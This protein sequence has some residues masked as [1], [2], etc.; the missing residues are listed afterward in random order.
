MQGSPTFSLSCPSPRASSTESHLRPPRVRGKA[1]AP[2]SL[3]FSWDLGESQGLACPESRSPVARRGGYLLCPGPKPWPVLQG[4][5]SP[6]ES[7]SPVLQHELER[8][9]NIHCILWAV[10]GASASWPPSTPRTA[11]APGA[12]LSPHPYPPSTLPSHCLSAPDTLVRF[13]ICS[14][15]SPS[16]SGLRELAP[17]LPPI[18][19]ALPAVFP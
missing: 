5:R 11:P 8:L 9:L 4:V 14:Y 10:P 3:R 16:L 1:L 6:A 13:L 19:V 12:C 7:A 2:R 17:A 15:N 18:R